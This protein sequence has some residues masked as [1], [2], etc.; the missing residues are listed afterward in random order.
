MAYRQHT[1]PKLAGSLAYLINNDLT[2][3]TTTTI[4]DYKDMEHTLLNYSCTHFAMVQGSPSTVA[5]LLH[6]LQYDGMTPSG[7]KIC[8]AMFT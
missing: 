6:F 1:K 3:H 5:P 2:K 8:R 4:L 7:N